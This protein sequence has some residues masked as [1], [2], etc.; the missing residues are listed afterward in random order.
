MLTRKGRP[1]LVL[2][3]SIPVGRRS[4]LA[5]CVWLTGM[6]MKLSHYILPSFHE[7][8]ALHRLKLRVA[9]FA[10]AQDSGRLATHYSELSFRHRQ[11]PHS[12]KRLSSVDFKV[13]RCLYAQ[14]S[15]L[16]RQTARY[17]FGPSHVRHG[18]VIPV[19]LFPGEAQP[20]L[21]HSAN[22]LPSVCNFIRTAKRSTM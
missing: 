16:L 18:S 2:L 11:L 10:E 12:P 6:L 20:P 17:L 3:L 15:L 5:D 1:R 4:G 13:H 8:V 9:P 21:L 7:I 22:L 14:F 19:R